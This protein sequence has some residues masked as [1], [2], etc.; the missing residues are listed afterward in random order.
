MSDA[1][2][3]VSCTSIAIAVHAISF[4]V[5]VLMSQPYNQ[6]AEQDKVRAADD[7][8]NYDGPKPAKKS[9]KAAV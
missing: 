6:Q 1:V 9:K 7:K 5:P 3:K 8:A 2:K 4:R